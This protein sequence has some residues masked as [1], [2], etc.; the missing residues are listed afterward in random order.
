M[1]FVIHVRNFHSNEKIG[2][3]K[4]RQPTK[5]GA[6]WQRRQQR[7]VDG[8]SQWH[9]GSSS[10]G[11]GADGSGRRGGGPASVVMAV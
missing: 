10:S 2:R 5:A 4:I 8:G 3:W 1:A 11:I 7:A 9:G 6:R